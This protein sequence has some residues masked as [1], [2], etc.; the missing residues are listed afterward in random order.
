MP[1]VKKETFN[2]LVQNHSILVNE[3]HKLKND[4]YEELAKLNEYSADARVWLDEQ[5][6]RMS[7]SKLPASKIKSI[8]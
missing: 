6:A 3:F 7:S 4:L 2:D 1:I 5:I 8:E